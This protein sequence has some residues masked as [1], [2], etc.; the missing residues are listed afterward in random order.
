[1]SKE[2]FLSFFENAEGFGKVPKWNPQWEFTSHEE[3]QKFQG[4]FAIG[5]SALFFCPVV[6]ALHEMRLWRRGATL[7]TPSKSLLGL[8]FLGKNR[9]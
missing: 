8:L 4:F 3:K 2:S 6:K 1:M 7:S 5:T 9:I